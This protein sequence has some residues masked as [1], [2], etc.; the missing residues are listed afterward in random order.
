LRPPGRRQLLAEYF[1]V[2]AAS[3]AAIEEAFSRS[4]GTRAGTVEIDEPTSAS[5]VEKLREQ[6]GADLFRWVCACSIYPRIQWDLTL[7]PGKR[8]LGP[9]AAMQPNLDTICQLSW[10]RTGRIPEPIRGE[11]RRRLSAAER[12]E[13]GRILTEF[14]DAAGALEKTESRAMGLPFGVRSGDRGASKTRGLL[15]NRS[16]EIGYGWLGVRGSMAAR[17]L[18]ALICVV[19]VLW[20]VRG[21]L[22][23]PGWS[24]FTGTCHVRVT[25]IHP[26]GEP[27]G[28]AQVSSIAG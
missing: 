17:V 23:S 27:A 10:F 2:Y 11:L 6:L 21:I 16:Y 20:A 12:E 15:I 18:V 26:Q 8:L 1:E 24:A 28:D 25:V 3:V 22:P 4:G 14:S 19:G 7:F 9:A 13:I 5:A